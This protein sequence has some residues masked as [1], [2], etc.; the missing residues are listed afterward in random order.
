M[1]SKIDGYNL[2]ENRWSFLYYADE[3]KNISKDLV[4]KYLQEQAFNV[5]YSGLFKFSDDYSHYDVIPNM[6]R[7]VTF[8]EF[9]YPY[10]LPEKVRNRTVREIPVSFP[11]L[12]KY[13][14]TDRDCLDDSEYSPIE[15]WAAL[16]VRSILYINSS[17]TYIVRETEELTP[18]EQRLK[19]KKLKPFFSKHPRHIVLKYDQ[20]KEIVQRDGESGTTDKSK[21]RPLPHERRG[22]WRM[23]S[24][25][26]FKKKRSVWVRPADVGK[27]LKVR[28]GHRTYEVIR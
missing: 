21:R 26:R 15:Y 18:R 22:H 19:Q 9:E 13:Y 5:D 12:V 28:I 14:V 27:G 8:P 3:M 16:V 24:A 20:V 17:T 7:D 2:R 11:S 1:L 10:D 25:D 23:L 6:F 4:D